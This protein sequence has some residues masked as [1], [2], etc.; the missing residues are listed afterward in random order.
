MAKYEN[1]QF[2]K[3]EWDKIAQGGYCMEEEVEINGKLP[4]VNILIKI[5]SFLIITMS[6]FNSKQLFNV[7]DAFLTLLLHFDL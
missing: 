5:A 3:F 1:R 2:F 4:E 6:N 7:Y